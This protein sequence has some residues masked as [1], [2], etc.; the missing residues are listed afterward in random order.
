MERKSLC[1]KASAK[2]HKWKMNT[3]KEEKK[4]VALV[5]LQC[6]SQSLSSKWLAAIFTRHKTMEWDW[7]A[8]NDA[9]FQLDIGISKRYSN[10]FG[11]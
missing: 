7:N 8:A 10:I 4:H 11:T 3:L 1:I 5:I 9:Q 2:M 6:Q